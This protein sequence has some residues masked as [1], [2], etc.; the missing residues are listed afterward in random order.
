MARNHAAPNQPLRPSFYDRLLDESPGQ[1]DE[2]PRPAHTVLNEIRNAVRRDLQNLLN[3][4][5]RCR[6][7][8]PSLA[9]L[10]TSLVNYGIPDFT[11]VAA[12]ISENPTELLR[13]IEDAVRRFEPRLTSVHLTPLNRQSTVDRSFR[14]RIEAVLRVDPIED[15]VYYESTLEPSTG[16]IEVE[17][18]AQ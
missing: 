4:R 16:T 7:W 1:A 17:G 3:T 8:P 12:D 9:E 14:F 6:S 2:P 15:H 13:L 10:E 5:W 11:S 18:A